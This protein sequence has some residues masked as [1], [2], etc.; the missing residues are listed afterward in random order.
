MVGPAIAGTL[1]PRGAFE[2]RMMLLSALGSIRPQTRSPDRA[3]KGKPN[4]E[5]PVTAGAPPGA[6][7]RPAIHRYRQF[8]RLEETKAVRDAF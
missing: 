5:G 8:V 3:S 2:G 6:G 1:L 7:G 4:R